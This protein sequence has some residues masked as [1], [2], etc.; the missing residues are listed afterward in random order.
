MVGIS[1]ISSVEKQWYQC[2]LIMVC[3]K[4]IRGIRGIASSADD[5]A[6]RIWSQS[7]MIL[8]SKGLGDQVVLKRIEVELVPESVKSR[9]NLNNSQDHDRFIQYLDDEPPARLN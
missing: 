8:Q 1:K 4:R 7:K 5:F 6:E 2:F 9:Y 3:G